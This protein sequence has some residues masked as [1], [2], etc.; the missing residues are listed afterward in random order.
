MS[1]F[2]LGPADSEGEPSLITNNNRSTILN[3]AQNIPL[4]TTRPPSISPHPRLSHPTGQT[5]SGLPPPGKARNISRTEQTKG[6]RIR[7][8]INEEESDEEVEEI[9]TIR[10]RGVVK[11]ENDTLRYEGEK[12]KTF[13]S[14]Y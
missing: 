8:I 5:S 12:F 2:G 14:R 1:G 6:Q 4:P 7:D 13:L 10:R 9:V 3:M 11:I